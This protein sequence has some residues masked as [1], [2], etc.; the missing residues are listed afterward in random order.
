MPSDS[1]LDSSNYYLN[2]IGL[3]SLYDG[4]L[5]P[6]Y[7]HAPSYDVIAPES[8][9]VPT[10]SDISYAYVSYK[11]QSLDSSAQAQAR[12]N[13]GAVGYDYVSGNMPRYVVVRVENS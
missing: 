10:S 6:L 5:K 13:I 4:K 8:Q 9:F 11:E 2:R 12:E 7:G 1:S 3:K